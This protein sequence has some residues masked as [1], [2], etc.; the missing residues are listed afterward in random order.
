MALIAGAFFGLYGEMTGDLNALYGCIA[1]I[2]I[3]D[4]DG[5]V[6][7]FFKYMDSI[8]M[9]LLF[10]FISIIIAVVTAVFIHVF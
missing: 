3:H 1:V 7:R 6:R 4:I 10:T 5:K 8:L 2:F 9:Y